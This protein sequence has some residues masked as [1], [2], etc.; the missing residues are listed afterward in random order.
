MK[1]RY[2]AE[3]FGVILFSFILCIASCN[4]TSSNKEGLLIGETGYFERKGPIGGSTMYM[5]TVLA[6]D[7]MLDAL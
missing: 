7:H 2:H 4:T 5:C 6:A 1:N 3:T